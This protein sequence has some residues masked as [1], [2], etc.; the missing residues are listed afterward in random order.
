[1]FEFI[2]IFGLAPF[3]FSLVIL[4]AILIG[5]TKT[6]VT[7]AGL[8]T[9]PIM[10]LIF[11]GKASTG[12]VLPMLCFADIFALKYYHQHADLK[13]VFRPMPWVIIGI[14]VALCVGNNISDKL[15]KQLIA[16]IIIV[17]IV[18]LLWNDINNKQ[19][20]FS[21][22]WW[23]TVVLGIVGGSATMIGNAAGPIMAVYLLSMRLPKNS[24]IATGVW[25]FFIINLLKVPLHI[26]F[27]ETITFQTFLFDITMIPFLAIGAFLGVKLVKVFSE[28]AYRN[29]I[30]II[31]IISSLRLLF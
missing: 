4:S 29:F 12:I 21:Q 5:S 7:G 16:I 24:Y 10:A 22:N 2:N 13:Y 23:F 1:M 31:V 11:G 17:C 14:L 25:F 18:F 8:I 3:E 27:W 20:Y 19:F 26:F 30:I 15:F 6:G 28:K 9:I